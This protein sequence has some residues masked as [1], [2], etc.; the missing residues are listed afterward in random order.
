[1]NPQTAKPIRHGVRAGQYGQN[2]IGL[3]GCYLVDGPHNSMGMGRSDHN[4]MGDCRGGDVVNIPS[5]TNE[6]PFVLAAAERLP[7]PRPV[8]V[9][10]SPGFQVFETANVA[11]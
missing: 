5:G 11:G 2:I 3:L 4:S 9:E 8:H 10:N 6:K 1:V 7:H